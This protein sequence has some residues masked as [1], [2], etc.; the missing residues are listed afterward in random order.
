MNDHKNNIL[1]YILML[2]LFY[3]INFFK[4]YVLNCKSNVNNINIIFLRSYKLNKLKVEKINKISEN[5]IKFHEKDDMV[6]YFDENEEYTYYQ[7]LTRT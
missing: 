6:Q 4:L 7:N 2:L 3:N 1:N 5:K